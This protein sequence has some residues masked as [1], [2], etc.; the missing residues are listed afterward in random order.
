MR[1]IAVA[2]KS[3]S[4]VSGP[5]MTAAS[6]IYE[7]SQEPHRYGQVPVAPLWNG[8]KLPYDEVFETFDA[9]FD[10]IDYRVRLGAGPDEANIFASE[11]VRGESVSACLASIGEEF[12]ADIA[13][14]GT[15]VVRDLSDGRSFILYGSLS[16][17][18]QQA[19]L[20]DGAESFART[21]N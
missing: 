6:V 9:E 1:Y 19:D 13:S 7:A 4:S 16:Q 11:W 5:C 3:H 20:A 10:G 2:A 15:L 8:A 12:F 21:L 17:M 14:S 18:R